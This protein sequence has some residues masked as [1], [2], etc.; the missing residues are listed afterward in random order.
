[1]AQKRGMKRQRS[2]EVL[3][4][5]SFHEFFV[6]FCFIFLQIVL[7]HLLSQREDL[8]EYSHIKIALTKLQVFLLE[9]KMQGGDGEERVKSADP[10][11]VFTL[12]LP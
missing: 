1:M 8:C 6:L 3:V 4:N 7:K 12:F 11:F 5:V 9:Y 10:L 2:S